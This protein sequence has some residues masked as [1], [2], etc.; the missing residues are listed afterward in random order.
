MR[1]NL[2]VVLLACL[3]LLGSTHLH[4]ELVI[5]V[6]A[7]PGTTMPHNPGQIHSVEFTSDASLRILA[8]VAGRTG[9]WQL[10]D[11]QATIHFRPSMLPHE[12]AVIIGDILVAAS[13]MQVERYSLL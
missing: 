10:G 9:V 13:T 4:P 3:P 1:L 12:S 5:N 6:P 2:L 11:N 8:T 7:A